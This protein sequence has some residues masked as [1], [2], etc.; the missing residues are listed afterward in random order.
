MLILGQTAL[1]HSAPVWVSSLHLISQVQPSYSVQ[2]PSHVGKY[3]LRSTS[4]LLH[5]RS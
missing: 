4:A 2:R 3:H 5:V 1:C